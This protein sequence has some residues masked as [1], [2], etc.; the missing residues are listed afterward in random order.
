MLTQTGHIKPFY[1]LW[2]PLILAIGVAIADNTLPPQ[3]VNFIYMENG[4]LETLQPI[5]TFIA[6]YI[7]IS[8]LRTPG[9]G[10]WLKVWLVLGT[11]GCLYI[12]LEEIS[13]GQQILQWQTGDFWAAINDQNETNLHNTSSWFDQKP[14]NLLMVGIIVGGILIPLLQRYNPALLPKQFAAIYPRRDLMVVSLLMLFSYMSKVIFKIAH[15]MIYDRPSELNETYMY[16]FVLLYL[17][18]LRWQLR[19]GVIPADSTAA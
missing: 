3:W 7:G 14:R 9:L 19:T 13:Y 12:G 18:Q 10:K 11:L 5:I 8:A 17:V 4:F 2:L 16:Y 1:A 15:F 6:V